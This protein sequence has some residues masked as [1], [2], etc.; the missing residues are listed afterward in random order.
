MAL[1]EVKDLRVHF[2]T[3]D[4][5]VKAV[6]GVNFSLDRGQT[7]GIVG[8]SGSGK[9]VTCL[10]I[11]GLARGGQVGG[12]ALFQ[13]KDLLKM[14][15]DE[16]R[17]VRGKQIAMIFQDPL[18]SLHPYYKVG[19]Q[20][21]EMILAHEKMSKKD[22][23]D[24]AID[25][26]R[27]VGVPKP[28]R[29]VD[30][31]PHQFSG[32]M[33]QRA[34]IAMALALDPAVLIADE[35]TTALDVTVQAQVLDLIERLQDEFGT[36]IIMITHDLGVVADFADDVLV[37]YGG[38]PVEIADRRSAYYQPHHP[39]TWGLLQSI[40]SVGAEHTGEKLHPIK[41]LPPSLIHLPT[42]CS[43]HPRCP[44]VMDVCKKE[45]PRLLPAG[46]DGAHL[47]ACHLSIDEKQRIWQ[48]EVAPTR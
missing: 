21:V 26:L 40:P 1:L 38:K 32:G 18:S 41:G 13:G 45:E 42:G 30:D 19:A 16:L 48:Q 33:R 35:P 27:L 2:R 24:R 14:H 44:Y 12:Q 6:D 31:Y 22:A 36:A 15:A 23:R 3:D 46:D 11:M 7:V 10:S 4:G 29:R 9:S 20:I 34:M 47:S 17:A 39:Y 5:I 28:D 43:F 37:M 25:L 8:E